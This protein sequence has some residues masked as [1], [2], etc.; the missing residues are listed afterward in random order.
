MSLE[1]LSNTLRIAFAATSSTSSCVAMGRLEASGKE[2]LK[3]ESQQQ[4]TPL[5]KTRPIAAVHARPALK[6]ET[7]MD[8]CASPLAARPSGRAPPA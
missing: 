5:D 3:G 8:P 4:S 7:S 1:R 2:P 6:E